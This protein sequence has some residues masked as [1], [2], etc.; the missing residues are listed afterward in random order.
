MEKVCVCSRYFL[1]S[2][3]PMDRCFI[4]F[5]VV[6]LGAFV[7]NTLLIIR[8][9]PDAMTRMVP[10]C[11]KNAG[12]RI[13]T[14][15]CQL[16]LRSDI[17]DPSPIDQQQ[18]TPTTTNN[19]QHNPNLSQ[20]PD[21]LPKMTLH[22]HTHPIVLQIPFLGP[23]LPFQ[24]QSNKPTFLQKMFF[25]SRKFTLVG[26]FGGLVALGGKPC[27]LHGLVLCSMDQCVWLANAV[28]LR[29]RV[30]LRLGKP[31]PKRKREMWKVY[32]CLEIKGINLEI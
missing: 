14:N 22:T 25:T 32:I 20:T 13:Q 26:F 12:L 23:V 9:Y 28:Y 10:F 7:Y 16:K 24:P 6:F 1:S 30:P 31:K 11:K 17:S 27:Y 19:N 2:S 29:P 3:Q 18:P 5:H 8:G 21:I 15:F 4:N